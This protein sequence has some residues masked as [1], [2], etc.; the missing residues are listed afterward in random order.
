MFLFFKLLR[1]FTTQ[2]YF[3][4]SFKSHLYRNINLISQKRMLFNYIALL[5]LKADELGFDSAF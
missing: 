1:N 5:T 2:W 3:V 4:F